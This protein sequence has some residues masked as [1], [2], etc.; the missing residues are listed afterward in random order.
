MKK[1]SRKSLLEMTN[2][3]ARKFFIKNKSYCNFDLPK[4]FDFSPMLSEL[5]KFVNEVENISNLYSLKHLRR[6]ENVNHVIFSSKDGK[7]SWRPLQLI[8]PFLYVLLVKEI[9]EK[10]NWN[11]ILE[12]F[13]EFQQN[14]RI[15]CLSIPVKTMSNKS[16]KAEQ[17]MQ[18]WENMEQKSISQSLKFKMSYDTDIADCYGSLYTHSIAWA[19]ETI[20]VAKSN[21]DNELLG[22]K[23]DSSIRDMQY[24]QTNSIPQGSVLMDFIAEMVLGYIDKL[25]SNILAEK[26]RDM[27][28]QIFRYRDDYR[29]FVNSQKDGTTILKELAKQIAPFGFKLNSSKTRENSNII[30]TALKEDKVAWFLGD[31][32]NLGIQKR[33]LLLHKHSISYPNSGSILKRLSELSDEITKKR[34]KKCIRKCKNQLIAITTDIMIHNPKSIPLC[35][36]VISKLL[37]RLNESNR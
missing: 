16:D 23:I 7:L 36:S 10:D 31:N 26:Y 37:C 34:D 30:S 17:V 24:G 33:L 25:L 28:Y 19:I 14:K 5:M 29:I 11:R 8:N 35:C 1:S 21:K 12:R 18:W 3:E 22:N 13:S 4:Y 15:R 9:T 6:S 20:E 32:E 2:K 27:D